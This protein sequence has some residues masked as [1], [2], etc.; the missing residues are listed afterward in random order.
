MKRIQFDISE[1][2]LDKLKGLV[3]ETGATSMAEVLRN[4]LNLYKFF[5]QESKNGGR[6]QV[7]Y[8]DQIIK[9]PC[10]IGIMPEDL[11]DSKDTVKEPLF[12]E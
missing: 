12:S 7:V 2:D 1:R 10:F 9:E 8:A 3:R 4:S 6:I 11:L 5:V